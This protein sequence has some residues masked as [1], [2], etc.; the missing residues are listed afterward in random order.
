MENILTIKEISK[1]FG[2]RHVLKRVSFQVPRGAI[3]GLI[4]PNG[5]GK[6]TIMKL[7]L[8]LYSPDTGQIVLSTDDSQLHPV[9][10]GALIESPSIYPFLT[11]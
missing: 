11:G 5:V 10:I 8:G 1:K 3:V 4:G 6:S 2:H 7:I 9:K